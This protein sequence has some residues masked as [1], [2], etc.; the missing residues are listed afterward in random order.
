VKI[1]L[2]AGDGIGAE[3]MRE[4]GPRMLRGAEGL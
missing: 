3:I 2:L 1:A 4:V